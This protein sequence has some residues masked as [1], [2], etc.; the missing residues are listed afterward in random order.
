MAKVGQLIALDDRQ[1]VY[2]W[3]KWNKIVT[4]WEDKIIFRKTR[5]TYI[6][7][8]GWQCHKGNKKFENT[9]KVMRCHKWQTIQKM[10]HETLHTKL[11]I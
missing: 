4:T 6:C 2:N 5:Y 1:F 11:I 10:I 8:L 3:Y 7:R 9:K